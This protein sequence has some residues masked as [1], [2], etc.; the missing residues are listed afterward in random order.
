MREAVA[1]LRDQVEAAKQE[2]GIGAK[3]FGK[4]NGAASKA[5]R[6]K[7]YVSQFRELHEKKRY[8]EVIIAD[9]S[10]QLDH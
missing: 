5:D 1:T 4:L 7:E 10:L 9:V 8:E 3:D 2:I 6:I